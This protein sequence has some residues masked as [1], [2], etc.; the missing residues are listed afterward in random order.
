MKQR[1]INFI[2]NPVAENRAGIELMLHII[3]EVINEHSFDCNE[4]E[5]RNT[6][7]NFRKT[8]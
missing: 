4:K 6:N 1:E 5:E 8:A 7:G 3:D 2:Y